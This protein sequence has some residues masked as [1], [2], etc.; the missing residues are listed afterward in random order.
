MMSYIYCYSSQITLQDNCSIIERKMISY[1]EC[2]YSPKVYR[3]IGNSLK[4][5]KTYINKYV[6]ASLQIYVDEINDTDL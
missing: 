2:R 4:D 6:E 1:D 5:Q 3:K